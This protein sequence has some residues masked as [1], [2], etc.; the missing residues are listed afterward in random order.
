MVP[1]PALDPTKPSNPMKKL[2]EIIQGP[3]ERDPDALKVGR[4]MLFATVLGMIVAIF[5]SPPFWAENLMWAAAM[6][7][8]GWLLGFIFGIPRSIAKREISAVS[9]VP[10]GTDASQGD[11]RRPKAM[12]GVNTNLEEISDWLTKIIV[13]VSLVEITKVLDALRSTAEIVAQG[14]GGHNEV[15]FAYAL[16]IYFS[17]AGFLGSYLLT[18]LYLQKALREAL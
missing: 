2:G 10:Q 3:P 11:G 6:S 9:G 14:T 1:E 16:I 15:S 8:L 18:R 4:A 13:G 7:S 5:W 12:D 17:V